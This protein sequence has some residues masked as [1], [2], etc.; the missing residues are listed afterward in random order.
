MT[1]ALSLL[2]PQL[3]PHNSLEIHIFNKLF[4]NKNH[5]KE[6]GVF[7]IV[8]EVLAREIKQEKETKGIQI[9]MEEIKLFADGM[10]LHIQNPSESAPKN[11]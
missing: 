3:S 9:S 8:L 11:Y 1:W 4:L 5:L 2:H 10:L 6:P 7:N